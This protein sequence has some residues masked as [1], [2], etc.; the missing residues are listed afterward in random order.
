[1]PDNHGAL[2]S[3]SSIWQLDV[4]GVTYLRIVFPEPA[5][6]PGAVSDNKDGDDGIFTFSVNP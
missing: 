5:I 4:K 2:P 6:D 1:M 3:F